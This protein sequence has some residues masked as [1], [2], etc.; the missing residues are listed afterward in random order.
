MRLNDPKYAQSMPLQIVGYLHTLGDG[1]FFLA[2][3][4]YSLVHFPR[5]GDEADEP[6][7]WER[8]LIYRSSGIV[9]LLSMF[10]IGGYTVLLPAAWKQWLNDCNFLFW[11]ESVVV[12]AFAA[13]WSTKGRAIFAEIGIE[14]L[15]VP[16][17]MFKNRHPH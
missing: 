8:P 3:A 4:F 10:A 2:L 1:V 13:A 5:S 7:L 15:A 11:M 17:E 12:W 14:L 16:M 6:R 9:I